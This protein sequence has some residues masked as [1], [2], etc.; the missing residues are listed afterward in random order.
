MP[1]ETQILKPNNVETTNIEAQNL[2]RLI[3]F[4]LLNHL[5]PELKWPCAM[6]LR[7][8]PKYLT[9]LFTERVLGTEIN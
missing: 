1:Q 3:K 2:R 5:T 9:P 6:Q 7:S 8:F 4:Q